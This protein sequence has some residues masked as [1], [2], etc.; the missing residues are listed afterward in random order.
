MTTRADRGRLWEVLGPAVL[1]G[2]FYGSAVQVLD[3]LA[4]RE[5]W[6]W[7]ETALHGV[8]L[9]V[10]IGACLG[11]ELRFSA[12]ARERAAVRQVV[13]AGVL[14][15]GAGGDWRGRLTAERWRLSSRRV[16]AAGI[17]A[18]LAVLVAVATLRRGGRGGWAWLHAAG[19]AL[20]GGLVAAWAHRRLVTVDRLR[21]QLRERL[22][23]V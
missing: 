20:A 23:S 5:V 3:V 16:G 7:G 11:L 19:L 18:L 14:P 6:S 9:A 8:V 15:V 22:T 12:V 10:G 4:F 1:S 21:A 13:S 2:A 17:S